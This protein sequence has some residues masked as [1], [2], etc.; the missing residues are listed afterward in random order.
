MHWADHAIKEL[1]GG[2][3]VWIYPSGHSME[4][5]V[6]HRDEVLLAPVT[7]D[8]L[9]KGDVVLCKVCGQVYLHKVL[10]VRDRQAQIGNNRGRVNGWTTS[11]YGRMI[12]KK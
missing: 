12:Q 8:N 2:R 9:S 1:R 5:L 11:V 4:P 10:A 3:Q 6:S 7:I